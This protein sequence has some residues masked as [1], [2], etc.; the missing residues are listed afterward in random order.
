MWS[1]SHSVLPVEENSEVWRHCVQVPADSCCCVHVIGP[2]VPM[3]SLSVTVTVTS[4]G[5]NFIPPFFVAYLGT[6]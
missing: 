1:T 5:L 3:L 4:A 2:C 6:Q